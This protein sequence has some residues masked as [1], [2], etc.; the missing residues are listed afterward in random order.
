[1]LSPAACINELAAY[2]VEDLHLFSIFRSHTCFSLMEA[3][4]YLEL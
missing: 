4:S 2:Y 1:M 3:N